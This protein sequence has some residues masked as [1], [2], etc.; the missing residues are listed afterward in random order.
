[1]SANATAIHNA[2]SRREKPFIAVNCRAFP[3]E[4]IDSALFGYVKGAFTG[5][6]SAKIEY[7]EAADGGTLFL[8]EFGEL[9]PAA[10]VRLLQVLQSGEVTPVG[11]TS[12]K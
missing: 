2:S 7:F 5:A 9:P 4:L 6:T 8:D 10:Q 1:M 11:G 3:G 12:S